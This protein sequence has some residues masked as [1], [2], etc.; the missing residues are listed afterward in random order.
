MRRSL[1]MF[2]AAALVAVLGLSACASIDAARNTDTTPAARV[3]AL[4]ADYVT[5]LGATAAYVSLPFCNPAPMP[6]AD[7]ATVIRLADAKNIA[8]PALDAAE[9]IVRE[10]RPGDPLVEQAIA[11]AGA[12][13]DA[14]Q[15]I[16]NRSKEV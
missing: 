16:V 10:R 14:F 4:R 1:S 9:R 13:L 11:A 2:H 7:A 8:G 12:A 5:A 6:C 15:R 3:Y